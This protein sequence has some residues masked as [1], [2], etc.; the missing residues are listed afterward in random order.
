VRTVAFFVIAAGCNVTGVQGSGK[1]AHEA[2]QVA[3]FDAID[4]R[5]ALDV[6]ITA[7]SAQ[8]IAIDG[9][10]NLV[11]LV[12]TE[13]SGHILTIRTERSYHAK[14]PLIAHVAMPSFTGLDL[15]GAGNVR[16][17]HIAGGDVA[18]TVS[19]AGKLTAAGSAHEL[20]VDLS[21]AG[22]IDAEALHVEHALVK[23][24]GTGDV[25][26]NASNALSVRISGAGHVRYD[27]HPAQ[28]YKQIS[29]VGSLEPR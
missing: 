3:A 6:E 5:G 25:D 28:L 7:G 2:R 27:G 15:S 13:V 17:E 20:D 4:V 8:Q 22:S 14:V 18:L 29:G 10:D 16:V 19:G 12:H 26:V 9:D 21:G 23:L 24:G 11:P 1:A